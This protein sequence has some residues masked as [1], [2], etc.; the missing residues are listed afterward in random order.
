MSGFAFECETCSDRAIIAARCENYR[1]KHNHLKALCAELEK[2]LESWQSGAKA[3]TD[4]DSQLL[5]EAQA[6][7]TTERIAMLE[8]QHAKDEKEKTDL[9]AVNKRFLEEIKV[10]KFNFCVVV[11]QLATA[12]K[13]L[14]VA[15][16]EC[17]QLKLTL[18]CHE[19]A[20]RILIGK[21]EYYESMNL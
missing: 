17:E 9:R 2:E 6:K 1:L 15:Q 10:T 19:T 7:A 4:R 20:Q 8:E 16:K 14:E 11:D 21:V 5:E 18:E 3:Q 13:K 12:V